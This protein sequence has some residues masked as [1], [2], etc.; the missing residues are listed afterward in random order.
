MCPDSN[1]RTSGVQLRKV[2][3]GRRVVRVRSYPVGKK[4]SCRVDN[5]DPGSTIGRGLGDTREEAEQVALAAA[6]LSLQLTA[7]QR[8]LSQ[9]IAGMRSASSSERPARKEEDV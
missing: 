6:E 1:D 9:R 8:A 4:F 2:R 7:S 3:V 5:V